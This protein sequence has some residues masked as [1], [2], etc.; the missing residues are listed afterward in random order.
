MDIWEANKFSQALTPHPC[1]TVGQSKCSGDTCGGTYSAERYAGVCDPDG[2]D[3]NPY[4][5]GVKDFYGPGMTVNTNSKFSVVTQF[6]T[7]AQSRYYVVG[8]KTIAQPQSTWPGTEGNTI[9]DAWCDKQKEVFGDTNVFKTKGGLAQMNKALQ[10]GMVLVMSL[11]NDH[12]SN[13]LWLDSSYPLDKDP[14]SPGIARGSCATSSGSPADT[15][16]A[17]A[18]ATVIFSNIKFGP[19][20]STFKA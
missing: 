10:G 9:T 4:R 3:F 17:Q 8:G 16:S 6:T 1:T 7:T 2:C 13:M 11:W 15:E 18:D 20:N 14:A 5:Q 12:Y 19:I